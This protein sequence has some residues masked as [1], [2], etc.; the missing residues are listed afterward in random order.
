MLLSIPLERYENVLVLPDHLPEQRYVICQADD[1][2]CWHILP[3]ELNNQ[4]LQQLAET[5]DPNDRQRF[6]LMLQGTYQELERQGSLLVLPANLINSKLG[7]QYVLKL[8][9]KA[10]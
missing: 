8:A 10:S 6:L 2:N 9:N 1:V 3:L 5:V 7:S 4:Q